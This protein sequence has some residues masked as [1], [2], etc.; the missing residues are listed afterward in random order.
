MYMFFLLPRIIDFLL[1][2]MVQSVQIQKHQIL[3]LQ[4]LCVRFHRRFNCKF[5]GFVYVILIFITFCNYCAMLQLTHNKTVWLHFEN[6][7]FKQTETNA[8]FQS[9]PS[10]KSCTQK[11]AVLV[12]AHRLAKNNFTSIQFMPENPPKSIHPKSQ[13]YILLHCQLC[14]SKSLQSTIDNSI[15]V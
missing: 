7:S 9:L 8:T 15:T 13:A 14:Y 12:S 11:I 4:W 3:S 6:A 1:L 5:N 10:P 2:V